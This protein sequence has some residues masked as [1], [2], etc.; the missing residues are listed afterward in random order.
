MHVDRC[1]EALRISIMCHGDTTPL[2]TILDPEESLCAAA[3]SAHI[4]SAG[5]LAGY[6]R[7][8]RRTILETHSS[9]T[10]WLEDENIMYFGMDC[11][12]R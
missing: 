12:T 9:A 5:T 11:L 10:A 7:G 1:I 2:F 4:G 8:W 6:T 3:D